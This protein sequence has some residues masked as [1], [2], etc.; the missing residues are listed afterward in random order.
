MQLSEAFKRILNE[1]P[2]AMTQPFPG[3]PLAAFVRKDVPESIR[4]NA[5]IAS[6]YLIEGECRSR[7]VG[8]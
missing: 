3:N 7:A 5:Q 6:D 4:D 1:Y 2:I 8:S